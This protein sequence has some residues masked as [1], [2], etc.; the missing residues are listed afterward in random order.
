M[1]FILENR[2]GDE[3][4]QSVVNY[5]IEAVSPEDALAQAE[6]Y[7]VEKALENGIPEDQLEVD[8]DGETQLWITYC[9]EEGM[10][11]HND[12][13]VQITFLT[14]DE[15]RAYAEKNLYFHPIYDF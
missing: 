4:D 2:F 10:C 13:S 1:F 14:Y 11:E 3:N 5:I 7:A 12:F 8:G 9:P 6:A 15:A